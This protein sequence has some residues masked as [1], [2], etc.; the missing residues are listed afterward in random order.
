MYKKYIPL[1]RTRDIPLL[2]RRDIPLFRGRDYP[3]SVG[4]IDLLHNRACQCVHVVKAVGSK[5][6]FYNILKI[7]LQKM[8]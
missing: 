2:R 6:V 3:C 7:V 4:L 5:F 1:L 8:H